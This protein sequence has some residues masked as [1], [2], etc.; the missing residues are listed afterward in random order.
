MHA[1]HPLP[2]NPEWRHGRVQAEFEYSQSSRLVAFGMEHQ[3]LVAA[4]CVKGR[5]AV[6]PAWEPCMKDLV[7]RFA[8]GSVAVAKTRRKH[9][10]VHVASV[11]GWQLVMPRDPKGQGRAQEPA[12]G[13]DGMHALVLDPVSDPVQDNRQ[14]PVFVARCPPMNLFLGFVHGVQGRGREKRVHVCAGNE[15]LVQVLCFWTGT[16]HDS[17]V[18]F[19]AP[20]VQQPCNHGSGAVFVPVW[21]HNDRYC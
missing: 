16:K 2:S 17:H 4:Q 13:N 18:H 9:P 10:H 20:V 5:A 7:V 15:P 19:C 12:I 14:L 11:R 1:P 3:V 21:A 8:K 6:L